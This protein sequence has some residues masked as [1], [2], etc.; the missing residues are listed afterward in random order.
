[1]GIFK[2][3]KDI[4]SKSKQN[5]KHKT[6]QMGNPCIVYAEN[7]VSRNGSS[8]K[9]ILGLF[10]NK[11]HGYVGRQSKEKKLGHE[12]KMVHREK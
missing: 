12:G 11:W 9:K 6:L 1:M 2:R 3:D 10:S 8:L 5:A 7:V 4:G